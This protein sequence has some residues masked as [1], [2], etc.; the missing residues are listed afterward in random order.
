MAIKLNIIRKSK[1]LSSYHGKSIFHSNEMFKV[2]ENTRGYSPV[3]AV[4]SEKGHEI[5]RLLGVIRRSVRFFPPSII[6]RCEVYGSGEYAD[7]VKNR[8]EL[9]S[10]MLDRFTKEVNKRAFL[11]EFRNIDNSLFGYEAFRRNNFL[12]INWLRV[13]NSLHSRTPEERLSASRRRQI[14]KATR[15][16]VHIEIAEKEEDIRFFSLMLKKSYSSKV[17]KHM[18]DIGFFLELS[19]Q[20]PEKEM[21]KIFLVKYKGKII[22]GS[23]CIFSKD[24]AYLWFS[25]GLR[26]SYAWV[27]PGV[28]AVWGA[29]SYAHQAGYD[30][31]EFMDAGLPF[32]KYGY[33]DFILRFGGKQTSTRRWF[34]FRWN[35]LNRLL[36]C[37]YG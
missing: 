27:Y 15:N 37:I 14:S 32:K 33:R 19:R 18:P 20:N 2:F 31:L 3:M 36:C 4:A 25:A 16:G 6:K 10:I 22:G 26:K 28:M 13:Y 12:P 24:R 23:L 29:I 35:W 5:G 21:A 8:E 30:H 34:R 11:I 1:E 7:S 17:R 9:F